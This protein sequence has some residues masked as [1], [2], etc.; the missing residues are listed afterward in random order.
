MDD[1][2]EI[3]HA[4][5]PR[6][7]I[8]VP[9]YNEEESVGPLIDR[10]VEVGRE[11]GCTWELLLVDDG[12]TDGTWATVSRRQPFVPELRAIKLRGNFGQTAAMVAGFDHSRGEVI[13][14]LDGDL[15]NDPADIPLLLAKLDEGHDIVSGWRKD[16]NDHWSRVIPSRVANGLISLTTRVHLH[17][18]GC[19]LKA[20]RAECIRNLDCYAEMHRF[21]PALASMTGARVAEIPVRHHPRRFGVSKYGFD[22]IF[23]VFSDM[24]AIN[25]I[26]RFSSAPLRGFL[27]A[28]VPF[29][30]MS[31]GTGVA[32]FVAWVFDW[33]VGK[34]LFFSFSSALSL[35]AVAMLLA[36]GMLGE[37]V[38]ALSDLSHT[39][40]VTPVGRRA[41][42]GG[43][44]KPVTAKRPS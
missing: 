33:T 40:L 26:I 16:R 5:R 20:Y 35:L 11:L 39:R 2:L 7:S 29:A 23:K 32:A 30:V 37:M 22:R 10:L 34:A 41:T 28:A 36:L 43:Q 25:L 19:S 1:D 17:D 6:L 15:Q 18:Y 3:G 13:V 12:S 24:F 21:F 38:V 44:E 42:Y 27:L 4:D 8:V 31:L 9:L 14:T